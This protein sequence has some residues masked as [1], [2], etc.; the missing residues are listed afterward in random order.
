MSGGPPID[1]RCQCGALY[2][3]VGVPKSDKPCQALFCLHRSNPL[4]A[5]DADFFL[6]YLLVQWPKKVTEKQSDDPPPRALGRSQLPE[7]LRQL[8][9][10]RSNLPRLVFG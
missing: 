6:K 7:Q 5:T 10:T 2:K 9:K 8:R 4:S 3:L 1:F